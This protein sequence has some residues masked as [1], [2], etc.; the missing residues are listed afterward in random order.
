MK[1]IRRHN[2]KNLP[3]HHLLSS[4]SRLV[5]VTKRAHSKLFRKENV[6]SMLELFLA[7]A[8]RETS[9]LMHSHGA[10]GRSVIVNQNYYLVLSVV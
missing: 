4:K 7:L 2:R 5:F 3:D 9:N 8:T 6:L 1:E 10:S